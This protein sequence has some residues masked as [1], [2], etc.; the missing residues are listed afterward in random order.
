MRRA[1][2]ALSPACLAGRR[3]L[4][5]TSVP[6]HICFTKNHMKVVLQPGMVTTDGGLGAVDSIVSARALRLR[7][8]PSAHAA[9][10]I[11]DVTSMS[12]APLGEAVAPAS[13]LADIHWDGYG[14]TEGDELY[15]TVWHNVSGTTPLSL[16]F[17]ARVRGVNPAAVGDPDSIDFERNECPDR[18]W[19]VEVEAKAEEAL[20]H[21]LGAERY[22]A[23]LQG[24]SLADIHG[25]EEG[26]V[27]EE[28]GSISFRD[29]VA[30]AAAAGTAKAAE[31]QAAV[32][33]AS[34]EGARQQHVQE[35]ISRLLQTSPPSKKQPQQQRA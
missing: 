11:G 10:A 5:S 29:P 28:P 32:K 21:L 33:A 4:S 17:P 13:A 16:P 7:V 25:G 1:L 20:P 15:H 27:F 31:A 34:E 9:T 14:W 3:Q 24:S 12:T 30:K 2:T 22:Q 6:E 8:G 35:Q 23:M 26:L 19:V 18:G